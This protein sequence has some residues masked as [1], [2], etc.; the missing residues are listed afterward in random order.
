MNREE[1]KGIL[2]HRDTMLLIDEATCKN[3]V[4]YGS[5]HINGDEWFLQGH[6]PD[7]PV[8]PG[9]I[10]CEVLAQS[11]CV[12][13]KERLSG[14][15]YLPLFTGL[16]KVRFRRPVVPGETFKTECTITRERPPFYFAKGKGYVG[17]E[18]CVEASLSFALT[19]V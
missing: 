9:V 5:L 6:F 11:T 16:E 13:L 10:L 1:L 15:R 4:A 8:V 3:D 2:P 19:E 7:K 18:L 17:G 14:E 12:L